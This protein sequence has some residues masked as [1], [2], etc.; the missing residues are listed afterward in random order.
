M[1]LPFKFQEVTKL[2]SFEL[3]PSSFKF[4]VVSLESDK[5]LSAKE[6]LP[7]GENFLTIIELQNN[8]AYL[9]Y[10]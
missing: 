2:T 1:T 8:M 7:N 4:G 3:S 9:F 5:Y 10:P 6:N